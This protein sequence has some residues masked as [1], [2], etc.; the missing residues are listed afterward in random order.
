[1][2]D[3][4]L[5]PTGNPSLYEVIANKQIVGRIA[6]F[7]SLR[8]PPR[9]WIAFRAVGSQ[10]TASRRR[11]RPP[12]RRSPGIGLSP[13]GMTRARFRKRESW[14]L[15]SASPPRDR[16]PSS[17]SG[18]TRSG[19]RPSAVPNAAAPTHTVADRKRRKGW[20]ARNNETAHIP[21]E[22]SADSTRWHP[23]AAHSGL[24]KHCR[25]RKRERLALP[26]PQVHI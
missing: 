1:M 21:S 9:G 20:D 19:A 25:Y 15:A 2:T 6:L 4:L 11:A 23:T 16:P 10:R 17:T 8:N 13:A 22:R 14:R 26:H 5:R 24:P 3:L 18:A 7:R 12:C